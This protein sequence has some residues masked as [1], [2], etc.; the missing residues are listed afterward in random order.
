MADLLQS[1]TI[2]KSS[3]DKL[4]DKFAAVPMPP[5]LPAIA[6]V[7]V[8]PEIWLKLQTLDPEI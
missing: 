2:K 1:L 5:N 6:P 3:G 7:K 8:N 4:K